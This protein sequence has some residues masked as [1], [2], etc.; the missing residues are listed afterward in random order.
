VGQAAYVLKEI[1]RHRNPAAHTEPVSRPLAERLRNQ[2]L[3]IG[4][5]G[6]LVKLA[7]VRPK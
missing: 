4:C 1:A 3:G 2:L 5:H 7:N 6:D